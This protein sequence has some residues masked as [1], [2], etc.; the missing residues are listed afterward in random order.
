[1]IRKARLPMSDCIIQTH[2]YCIEM[3]KNGLWCINRLFL[4]INVVEVPALIRLAMEGVCDNSSTALLSLTID[5]Q[6]QFRLGLILDSVAK[7]DP[8]LVWV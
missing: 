6:G 8:L 1:M 5:I 3:S 7:D 4:R 2:L